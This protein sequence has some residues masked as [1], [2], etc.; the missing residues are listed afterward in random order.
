MDFLSTRVWWTFLILGAISYFVSSFGHHGR[1]T[2]SPQI[3]AAGGF[4]LIVFVATVFI[5]SGWKGG[6]GIVV[7]LFLW[8]V[9]AERFLWL[10]FRRFMPNENNMDYCQFI[11]KSHSHSNSPKAPSSMKELI[12]RSNKTEEMLLEISNR[13]E[14]IDIL[15]KYGK[16]QGDIS[17][18]FWNLIRCGTN[19]FLSQSVIK[20][21]KMLS[22]YLE[23]KIGGVSDIEIALKL[24]Q[25]LGG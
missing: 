3:E 4:G 15:K 7:V 20:S 10:I 14:I 6:T 22:E 1:G 23:M 24:T 9:I 2:K 21:P 8:A 18:I 5:S 25:S 13:S 12:E 19:E 16:N 11:R 17:E